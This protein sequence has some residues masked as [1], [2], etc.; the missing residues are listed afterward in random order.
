MVVGSPA[1]QAPEALDD[2]YCDDENVDAMPQKEDVWA[3]GVTF[4]QLLFG[5]LPFVGDSLFEIVNAIQ[6]DGLAI[7]EGTD[8]QIEEVLS[9]MLTID[10]VK[11]WG[12]AELLTHPAIAGASDR[13][14]N[15]PPV[16]PPR[17]K[18]GDAWEVEATV[19]S[20]GFLLSDVVSPLG[21]RS[22]FGGTEMKVGPGLTRTKSAPS[23]QMTLGVE[24]STW[25]IG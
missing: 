13:A 4:F 14:Q 7:P 8:P 16:P 24:C 21:R 1:Y 5:R 25:A 18:D 19:C 20:E 2:A 12:I 10:P 22:S 15:L 11:R 9:G 6:S 23:E 17:L 3:L